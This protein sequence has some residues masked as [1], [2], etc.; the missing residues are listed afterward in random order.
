MK[1]PA[2]NARVKDDAAVCG[3]CGHKLREDAA[4][5]TMMGIPA[6]GADEEQEETSS[7]EGSARS[8]LFGIPAANRD[9]DEDAPPRG[10]GGRSVEDDATPIPENY[11]GDSDVRTQVADRDTLT[12]ALEGS[13]QQSNARSTQFGLP[14]AEKEDDDADE[15][16]ASQWSLGEES[17][18]DGD[19]TM[20]A[21]ANLLNKAVES[22]VKGEGTG[23]SKP[24]ADVDPNVQT[25]MG[26]QAPDQEEEDDE[27][28]YDDYDDSTQALSPEELR[29]FEQ[30]IKAEDGFGQP[31]EQA[32]PEGTIQQSGGPVEAQQADSAQNQDDSSGSDRRRNL[33]QKLKKRSEE[34]LEGEDP[35]RT[36][37]G[38]PAAQRGEEQSGAGNIGQDTIDERGSSGPRFSIPTPGDAKPSAPGS[39]AENEP[40]PEPDEQEDEGDDVRVDTPRSGVLSAKRP[41]S[42]S[43]GDKKDRGVLESSSSYRISGGSDPQL[44]AREDSPSAQPEQQQPDRSEQ[45][46]P[47]PPQE[48]QSQPSGVQGDKTAVLGDDELMDIAL[49]DTAAI[50]GDDASTPDTI[51]QDEIEEIA[52]AETGVADPNDLPGQIDQAGDAAPGEFAD[53]PADA[54][55]SGVVQP[56]QTGSGV[57]QPQRNRSGV[58]QPDVGS[59]VSQPGVGSAA[60]PRGESSGVVQPGDSA[61]FDQPSDGG[62]GVIQPDTGRS[63]SS[64]VSQPTDSGVQSPESSPQP[65]E[66]STQLGGFGA[67][68]S[69]GVQQPP[70][71]A[72]TGAEQPSQ[73]QQTGSDAGIG[74]PQQPQQAGNSTSENF[75]ATPVGTSTSGVSDSG[76]G[77]GGFGGAQSVPNP[78][79]MATPSQ[80]ER[81]T[82]PPE[83]Q[84]DQGSSLEDTIRVIFAV[85]GAIVT[86]GA[87]GAAF[88][89]GA[90]ELPML[91]KGIFLSP[92]GIGLLT[93]GVGVLPISG[94]AKT[95]GLALMTILTGAALAGAIALGAGPVVML[96]LVG[97]TLL[98]L[99]SAAFPALVKMIK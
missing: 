64:G 63:E 25:L 2:C 41:R 94:G 96:L 28:D 1:C 99:C 29:E 59:G 13:G 7:D 50:G 46:R 20:V 98:T 88:A 37:A 57:Q 49:D 82:Q 31:G 9:D 26:M 15:D 51:E 58:T 4:K 85:I 72:E 5:K 10:P 18:D 78:S 21:S 86:M 67:S 24:Q 47:H 66:S 91:E 11:E 83:Q 52:L 39:V 73:Q 6:M 36:A 68:E 93:L 19:E 30:K 14:R 97:G 35:R 62:S 56:D 23:F 80:K 53:A 33:L 43:D 16:I 89:E 61:G 42:K 54:S 45:L 8:T 95:A 60:A 32:S 71:R 40:E 75:G 76:Q 69:S 38:I 79:Q 3:N 27:A 12:D 84:Q 81:P 22:D 70:G 55:T 74:P 48:Q 92:L 44:E 87:G 34:D 65:P 17:E 77:R 90:L